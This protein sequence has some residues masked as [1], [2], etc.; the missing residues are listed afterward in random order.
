M[1]GCVATAGV[2][3]IYPWQVVLHTL[4]GSKGRGLGLDG[5]LHIVLMGQH[6][7]AG[8]K[9]AEFS[10]PGIFINDCHETRLL[11]LAGGALG[12][13]VSAELRTEPGQGMALMASRFQALEV[14]IFSAGL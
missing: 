14:S 4:A 3:C 6:P 13:L 11:W 5:I 8:Y 9:Q 1:L 12:V 10:L 7:T 2:A